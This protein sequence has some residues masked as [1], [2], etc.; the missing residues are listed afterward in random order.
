MKDERRFFFFLFF[1]PSIPEKWKSF[2]TKETIN[3]I[4]IWEYKN[5]PRINSYQDVNF[6]RQYII[7]WVFWYPNSVSA[8][9]MRVPHRSGS[10]GLSVENQQIEKTKWTL[11]AT[12]SL[13]FSVFSCSLLLQM[14]STL[15]VLSEFWGSSKENYI[16]RLLLYKIFSFVFIIQFKGL[17]L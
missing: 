4:K 1:F 7:V 16:S 14:K 8:E 2:V 6:V 3:S 5:L 9:G 13:H 15:F 11:L 17:L 10:R 12:I